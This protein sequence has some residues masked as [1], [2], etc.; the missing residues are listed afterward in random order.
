MAFLNKQQV[1]E[2]AR[3]NNLDLAG[4]TW[5]QM[6]KAI[7]DHMKYMK[8]LGVE[9]DTPVAEKAAA[10]VAERNDEEVA[11]LKRKLAEAE[12][13]AQAVPQVPVV[14]ER[15]INRPQ[16]TMKDYE[17][18]V[19]I[20]SPEQRP[21]QYQRN[22]W[23]E[24][25]GTQK[26]TKEVSFDVGKMSPFGP[27]E[28]GTKNAT[29]IVEETGRKIEAESTMPKFSALI[30]YRP[31]RDLCAI[32]E[33]QGRRGYLWTHQRLPNIKSMLQQMG[34]YEEMKD[35][36]QKPTNHMV[37]I[38]NLLCC[39]IGFTNEMMKRIQRELRKRGDEDVL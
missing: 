34:V 25:V 13:K 39:D 17:N 2:Y 6:Q 20:A 29:Y 10:P 30:T 3:E 36:W 21:T 23:Y 8:S 28:S 33:Y 4:L 38:A 37:Y 18:A 35:R 27:D 15:G 12:A 24:K 32:A 19:L 9:V 16:P 26:D 22:K 14:F 31:T 5:P 7:S 1:A 11:E